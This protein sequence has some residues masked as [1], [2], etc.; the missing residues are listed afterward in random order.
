MP[1]K[2]KAQEWA[3]KR[4]YSLFMISSAIGQLRKICLLNTTLE[5]EILDL[6]EIIQNL[7][8]LEKQMRFNKDISKLIFRA[9]IKRRKRHD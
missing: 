4:N 8:D 6:E 5:S 3:S 9:Q 2:S 7:E 1:W